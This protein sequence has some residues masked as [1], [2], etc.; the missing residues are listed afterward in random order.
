M[1]PINKPVSNLLYN[2]PVSLLFAG[3]NALLLQK[4]GIAPPARTVAL[5]KVLNLLLEDARG[6]A[7][8][9]LLPHEQATLVKGLMNQITT[10]YKAAAAPLTQDLGAFCSYC[11]SDLPGLIEVEHTVPKAL[12]P[13]FATD[14]SCF[15]LSCGPCNNSKSDQPSRAEV[16]KWTGLLRPT[17]QDL[18]DEVRIRRYVWPDLDASCWRDLPVQLEYFDI[19]RNQWVPLS[20]PDDTNFD[21]VLIAYDVINHRVLADLKV[22]GINKNNVEVAVRVQARNR[23]YW[24]EKMI[25]LMQ[26]NDDMVNPKSGTYDR[27]QMNRTKAWFNALSACKLL[28]SAKNSTAFDVLWRQVPMMGASSGFYAVWVT[29]LQQFHDFSGVNYASRFIADTNSNPYYPN[30]CTTDLP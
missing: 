13:K 29:V 30:T 4:A 20:A 1:R 7:I 21:N 14:W 22:G 8:S 23:E 9:G 17:E 11:G 2:P 15:L 12:Y 28:G 24:A 18:Y 6:K 26:F 5:S 16:T 19:M 10:V 3:S 27:R 25:D